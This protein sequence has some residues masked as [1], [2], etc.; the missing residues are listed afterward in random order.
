VDTAGD[1]T[2]QVT[3]G[4][5]PDQ[6]TAVGDDDRAHALGDHLLGGVPDRVERLDRDHV[7]RHHLA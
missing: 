4:D 5:D 1:G 2:R 7:A 3:F 6:A